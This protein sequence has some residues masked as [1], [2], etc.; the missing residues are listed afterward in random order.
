MEERKLKATLVEIKDRVAVITLNRVEKRNAL[1]A[2]ILDDLTYLVDKFSED[3]DVRVILLTGAGKAFCAGGDLGA[4]VSMDVV[5]AY[6]GGITGNIL[7]KKMERCRKPIIAAINGFC[8]GGGYE[9]ALGCDIRIASDKAKIGLP[10]VC[11]G[12]IPGSGGSQRLPRLI[13]PSLAKMVMFTG[14]TYDAATALRL[15]LVDLVYPAATLKQ[16]ALAF[17]AHIAE[18]APLALEYIKYAVNEGM[19]ADLD[20]GL[21]LESS[22]FGQLYGTEDQKEAMSAFLEKRPRKPFVGR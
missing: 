13:G 14:D 8:L 19:Q 17:A 4:E 22:L 15:G 21:L 16:D 12:V 7:M 11:M 2:D 9:L 10:E 3:P 1:N 18:Q 6:H 20:R 5:T